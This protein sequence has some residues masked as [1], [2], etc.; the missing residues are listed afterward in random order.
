MKKIYIVIQ[1]EENKK[2]YAF[3]D[4]IRTGENLKPFIDRHKADIFHLCE[5]RK[6]AEEIAMR[7]NATYKAN[8]QFLF[9]YP[10]F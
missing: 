2:Y 3:A 4:A 8:N 5:S 9:D 1:I 10:T 6:Q 7:W